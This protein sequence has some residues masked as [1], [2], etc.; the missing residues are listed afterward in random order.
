MQQSSENNEEDNYDSNY[1][2]HNISNGHKEELLSEYAIKNNFYIRNYNKDELDNTNIVYNDSIK[3]KIKE[4]G[5]QNKFVKN[6]DSDS[7]P[8]P[9]NVK[10][11]N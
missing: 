11:I 8:E 4:L 6:S 9:F 5:I 3:H 1:V 2:L 7:E 10:K